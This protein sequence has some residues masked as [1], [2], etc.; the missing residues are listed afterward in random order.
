MSAIQRSFALIAAPRA[1]PPSTQ[2]PGTD[3]PTDTER[4][5]DDDRP[6]L[7]TEASRVV[8]S[9]IFCGG[10]KS[11]R[12]SCLRHMR[13]LHRGSGKNVAVSAAQLGQK[14]HFSLA[15]WL[16]FP[17]FFSTQNDENCCHQKRFLK[18]KI[19]PNAVARIPMRTFTQTPIVGWDWKQPSKAPIA[20]PL[21]RFRR[22]NI[23]W[24]DR[25]WTISISNIGLLLT[26]TSNNFMS[27]CRYIQ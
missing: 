2:A 4:P 5:P 18:L 6:T 7:N 16:Q 26:V 20:H 15:A 9:H 13:Q 12:G 25:P 3:W 17:H 23:G 11:F 27:P 21:R 19:H 22:V 8:D 10:G 14:Y 24:H 1:L